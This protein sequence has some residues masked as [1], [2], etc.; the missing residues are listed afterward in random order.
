MIS[1]TN[2]VNGASNGHDVSRTTAVAQTPPDG[3]STGN[4]GYFGRFFQKPTPGPS[5]VASP[6]QI[7]LSERSG[8]RVTS[9][10]VQSLVSRQDATDKK[11][12]SIEG[13]L[14]DIANKLNT[15][16]PD[17][18]AHGRQSVDITVDQGNVEGAHQTPEPNPNKSQYI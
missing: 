2:N 17:T 12:Q 14:L 5:D 11:L 10:E 16:T 18:G 6:D 8:P 15:N 4:P 3:S 9:A 1:D 7:I 13:L